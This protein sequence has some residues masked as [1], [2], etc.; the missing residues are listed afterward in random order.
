[1]SVR[2]LLFAQVLDEGDDP[3]GLFK[4]LAKKL[5][6]PESPQG[7][8]ASRSLRSNIDYTPGAIRDTG[9]PVLKDLGALVSRGA[10]GV[11]K[12]ALL[13]VNEDGLVSVLHSLFQFGDSSYKDG[14]VELFAHRDEIHDDR[15]S[16]ILRLKAIQFASNSSFMGAP[17]LELK[18]H[19]SGLTSSL[20]K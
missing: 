10:E 19:L 3:L 9:F 13:A 16:A 14:P 4:Y 12:I 8:T 18:G 20:L 1:M 6:V 5:T 15:L 7:F 11:D 17:Q 2:Y